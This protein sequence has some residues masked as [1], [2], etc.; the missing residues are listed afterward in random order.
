MSLQNKDT[1]DMNRIEL[2]IRSLQIGKPTHDSNPVHERL[3]GLEEDDRMNNDKTQ[4]DIKNKTVDIWKMTI[5]ILI[6]T[7]IVGIITAMVAL[8]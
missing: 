3:F 1:K 7:T 5:A 6:I 2:K 8:K 4:Q